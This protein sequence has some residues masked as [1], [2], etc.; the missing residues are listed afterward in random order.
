M[1]I[2]SQAFQL[3]TVLQEVLHPDGS[4]GVLM[5]RNPDPAITVYFQMGTTVNPGDLPEMWPILPGEVLTLD[6][7]SSMAP[8][9]QGAVWMVAASGTPKI[10]I[11]QG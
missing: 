11:L 3:S 2:R 6:P 8:S 7:E 5:I 4:R 10:Y 1:T 9:I